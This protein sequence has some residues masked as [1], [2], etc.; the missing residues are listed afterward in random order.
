M[1]LSI[2]MAPNSNTVIVLPEDICAPVKTDGK[3]YIVIEYFVF[4]N[5]SICIKV[6]FHF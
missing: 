4:L 6:V 2:K 5:Q 1:Q 3:G